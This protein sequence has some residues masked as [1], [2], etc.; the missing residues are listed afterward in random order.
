MKLMWKFAPKRKMALSR[1]GRDRSVFRNSSK[2]CLCGGGT[3]IDSVC[4]VATNAV[5]AAAVDVDDD[6]DDDDDEV[7]AS[8][9]GN[10]GESSAI[11]CCSSI[12]HEPSNK[13]PLM[14][15]LLLLLL[16]AGERIESV[17]IVN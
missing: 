4:G 13:T 10:E 12:G 17:I 3:S 1:V 11:V 9:R 14:L 2:N 5:A 15:L 8:D 6:D 7:T 16:L